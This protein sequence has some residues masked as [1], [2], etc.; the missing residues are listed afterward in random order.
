MQF[1]NQTSYTKYTFRIELN[2]RKFGNLEIYT[3]KIILILNYNNKSLKT[4]HFYCMMIPKNC[5]LARQK[6]RI[7]SHGIQMLYCELA[8][9]RIAKAA[10][11][12]VN[13]Y[14]FVKIQY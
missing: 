4:N 9:L 3:C 12:E 2:G 6:L 8:N 1:I 10:N 7:A 13:L 11:C 5:E 14:S